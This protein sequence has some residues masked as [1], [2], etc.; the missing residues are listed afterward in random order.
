MIIIVLSCFFL[1]FDSMLCVI[2][3]LSLVSRCH[4]K[5]SNLRMGF[6]CAARG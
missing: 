5:K 3:E 4:K 2:D 1:T 6:D